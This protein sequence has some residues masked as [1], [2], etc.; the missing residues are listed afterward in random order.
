MEH[1]FAQEVLLDAIPDI[2]QDPLPGLLSRMQAVERLQRLVESANR[3]GVEHVLCYVDL[4]DFRRVNADGGRGAGDTILNEIGVWLRQRIR[5][6][7]R[8]ARMGS[9]EF[10]I[11]MEDA[12][13]LEGIR[14]GRST[15]QGLARRSFRHGMGD[16]SVAASIGL[17]PIFRGCSDA[18]DI[19]A[20]ADA[21][22]RQAQEVYPSGLRVA[23]AR[24]P[25]ETRLLI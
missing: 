15:R 2:E 5:P 11:L 22:C 16:F 6:G 1:R 21:A 19:L 12:P 9:D 3:W 20:A 4:E 18:A 17:V 8:V 24:A 10:A 25:G 7:D 14:F 23:T 13:L